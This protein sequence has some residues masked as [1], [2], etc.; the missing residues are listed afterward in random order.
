MGQEPTCVRREHARL[1]MAAVL[2][3]VITLNSVALAQRRSQPAA[4]AGV[5]LSPMA[6]APGKTTRVHVRNASVGA[7][8]A[9]WSSFACQS[10]V[11]SDDGD[12]KSTFAVTLP[13]DVRIGIGVARVHGAGG[14]SAPALV[15]IDDLP[16][17]VEAAGTTTR[18][19]PQQIELPVAV[20]GTC[21]A[22]AS[23][24]FRFTGRKGQQIS[25]ELVAVRLGSAMD[26]VIRLLDAS[27]REIAY[28]DD[29]PA[30]GG[31]DPRLSCELPGDGEYLLEVRDIN[32]EG[33]DTYRYRLRVGGSALAGVAAD[34]DAA[35][36]VEPNDDPRKDGPPL[37]VPFRITGDFQKSDDRDCFRFTARK[38]DRVTI[39]SFARSI[40]SPCDV[41]LRLLRENGSSLAA[42]KDDEPGEATIEHTFAADG[43][44]CLV[45]REIAGR[46]G[47]HS[48]YRI[49][50]ASGA[51]AFSLSLDVDHV[52]APAG[53][54]F[55]LVVKATRRDYKGDISLGIETDSGVMLETTDNV[56][57]GDKVETT[58]KAKVPPGLKPGQLVHFRVVGKRKD[59]A[60]SATA[61]N[62]AALRQLFPRMLYP[63]PELNGLI[64]LGV[65][66]A[67]P[68]PA[69]AK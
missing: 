19:N 56:I 49:E 37:T 51:P 68:T 24:F 46:S 67:K 22:V 59:D 17:V 38:G 69:V 16:T 10:D 64:A 60:G 5:V 27:G 66:S 57:K 29:D 35:P 12:R 11:V 4:P 21:E 14:V 3:L 40:G 44:Y 63:P 23:D 43:T 25:V 9:L 36:E 53:G 48:L 31:E 39:K 55:P 20:E 28:C 54:Q 58:L 30:T 1:R 34:D 47:P 33:G 7:E 41:S 65:T 61:E 52:E 13:R 32:Y 42:S 45:A 6:V 8:P 50:A 15:M 2:L 26:P 62:G 18:A